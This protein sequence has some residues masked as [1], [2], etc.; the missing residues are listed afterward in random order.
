ML[1][2][3][4]EVSSSIHAMHTIMSR[5][6]T[7]SCADDAERLHALFCVASLPLLRR[8]HWQVLRFASENSLWAL[9]AICGATIGL[10]ENLLVREG[11]PSQLRLLQQQWCA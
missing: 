5:S 11:R 9:W 1:L 10:T 6:Q 3:D 8:I 4:N 2:T 7:L